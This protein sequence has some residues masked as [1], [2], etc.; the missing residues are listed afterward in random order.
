MSLIPYL[1]FFEQ[2]W[3]YVAMIAFYGLYPLI[4]CTIY[5][6][7]A[8]IYSVRR[9]GTSEPLPE[10]ELPFV[11]VI[12]PAFCEQE[13]IAKS[14]SAALGI[15]YPH[16][17]VIVVNDGSTD[18]TV[19]MVRPFLTDPRV[20]LLD[21]QVNEGKAMALNDAIMCSKGELLFIMDAD[22]VPDRNVLRAMVP[23]FRSAR[24]AGVAGNPRVRNANNL[25]SRLQAVEFSSVIGLMRRAQ[26]IWGRV[27]CIS[28]VVGMFRK[29]A[30]IDVGLYSPGM[31]TED[32]D[33]TWKL[34]AKFYDIRYEGSALVWMIVPKTMKVWWRQRR[35]WA[36]GLGQVL[37][38]N[39][40]LLTGWRWRRMHPLYFE[41]IC[42]YLWALT[43][44]FV[45]TYWV[46]CY[47][48]GH[49]PRGGSP[50]P[51]FWGM[52]IY[53]FCLTQLACGTWLDSKYDPAIVRHYPVSV[54]YPTFYWFLL[55]LSTSVFTTVGL[56]KRINAHQPTRWNIEHS[57]EDSYEENS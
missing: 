44:V 21:K 1:E 25:L 51:N 42:S 47:S 39:S 16:F 26:R 54:I 31:A 7:T 28:G 38:R 10:S 20:R 32:I 11:S 6:I 4:T 40:F 50:I 5:I 41:S 22:A 48:V 13:V 29:S 46:L 55:T 34:Q 17:E 12:I 2:S 24:V 49:P 35:R 8:V 36:M 33:L 52:L 45:T 18:R 30:L 53:T 57:Y 23:H 27:M 19:E 9:P 56:F 15:N 14:V 43:F 3:V 37:R